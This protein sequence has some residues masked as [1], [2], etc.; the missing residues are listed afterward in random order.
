MMMRDDVDDSSLPHHLTNNNK[1]LPYL[2]ITANAIEFEQVFLSDMQ[3]FKTV[4]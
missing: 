3:K 1:P 2:F 4:C